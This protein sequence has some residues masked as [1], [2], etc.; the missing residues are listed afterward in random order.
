MPVVDPPDLVVEYE[1]LLAR[2]AEH[3]GP[4]W[5]DVL[6]WDLAYPSPNALLSFVDQILFRRL[7]DFVSARPT[8][9]VLDCGANIGYTTLHYKRQF[10]GARITAFEPDPAFVSLLRRNL[11]AN[12]ATDVEVVEAAV[13]T[14]E[15]RAAWVMESTDG[16][17]LAETH[18]NTEGGRLVEVRTVDLRAYLSEDVDL[19]KIDVEGAEFTLLPHL[20][21]ALDR[22]KNVLVECH[23]AEQA[24]YLG[25][26]RILD[27]LRA[28]GFEISVNSYG[29]WRDLIRRHQPAP[30][31]AEQY[32]IVSGWRPGARPLVHEPTFAPYVGL[33]DLVAGRQIARRHETDLA[34]VQA[35]L[36]ELADGRCGRHAVEMTGPFYRDMGQSW[37]WHCA[38]G[39]GCGD[40]VEAPAA[41]SMLVVEDGRLLG[42]GHALH[43]DVRGTGA[44]HFSH[45]GETL[46]FSTSDNTDPNTNG[47]RYTLICRVPDAA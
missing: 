20:R 45:W 15:G 30:L 12:Q 38:E 22:V 39:H 34:N 32:L 27:T 28:A 33:A 42:P 40:S 5:T 31:H 1:Q 24:H 18:A 13:W 35:V 41:S 26:G 3:D 19:L 37:I 4:G 44:G 7:N 10:P 11:A 8:P 43:A 29:P 9:R 21:G 6:G 36:A 16:S 25:L 2:L 47:R 17:R 46:L 14:A 23:V